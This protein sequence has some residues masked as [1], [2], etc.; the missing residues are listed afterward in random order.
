M[1]VLTYSFPKVVD[2]VA[3]RQDIDSREVVC[4]CWV[5]MIAMYCEYRHADIEVVVFKV[6]SPANVEVQSN[7]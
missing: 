7:G 3:G 6:H 5:I 1:H 2:K 4:A